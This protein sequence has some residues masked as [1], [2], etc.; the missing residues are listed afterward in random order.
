MELIL[1][2]V[3]AEALLF[4]TAILVG[5]AAWR[6]ERDSRQ[7]EARREFLEKMESDEFVSDIEE[8]LLEE[9]DV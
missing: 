8:Y 9:H 4:G 5:R 1:I 6:L 3:A 2:F 7:A